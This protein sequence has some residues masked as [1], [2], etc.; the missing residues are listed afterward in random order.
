M[1]HI[2]RYRP[3]TAV[4]YPFENISDLLQNFML[5]PVFRRADVEPQIKI[6]V[7]EDDSAYT[8]KAEIPGVKKEDIRVCI[9]GDRVS[10]SAE[11][12]TAETAVHKLLHAERH[13]GMQSRT[14]MLASEIDDAKA[15]AK[16]ENGLLELMLPK[17]SSAQVTQLSIK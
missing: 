4:K 2:V 17:K 8:V 10:I 6:D 14:F 16:Y 13:H 12:E 7:S 9:D 5:R 3:L 11:A 1:T 15:E